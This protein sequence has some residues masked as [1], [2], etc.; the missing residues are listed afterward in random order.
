MTKNK[1]PGED[2]QGGKLGSNVAYYKNTGSQC[3]KKSSDVEKAPYFRNMIRE[4]GFFLS[5]VGIWL[6][7]VSLLTN[8]FA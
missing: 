4:K 2:R 1:D 6:M 8:R 7:H 3:S 5:L